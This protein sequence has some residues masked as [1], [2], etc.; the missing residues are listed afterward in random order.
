M[1]HLN[2]SHLAANI[3][4]CIATKIDIFVQL[5][6]MQLSVTGHSRFSVQLEQALSRIRPKN[7]MNLSTHYY[8]YLTRYFKNY[9]LQR[10]RHHIQET[11]QTTFI[12]ASYVTVSDGCYNEQLKLTNKF[13]ARNR[14][15]KI[16]NNPLV[17][18]P[19]RVNP[20]KNSINVKG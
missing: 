4:Y 5:C 9:C 18:Y 6:A 15:I 2:Q 1:A 3:Q 17:D 19:T 16:I 14:K 7:N 12:F 10:S 8:L 20:Q 13:S 11:N